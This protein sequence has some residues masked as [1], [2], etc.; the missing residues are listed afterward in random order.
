MGKGPEQTLLQGGHIEGMA[1]QFTI[2]KHPSVNEWI[3][4][5]VHLHNGKMDCLMTQQFHFWGFSQRNPKH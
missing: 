1:V 3:K 4:N 5:L 2:A